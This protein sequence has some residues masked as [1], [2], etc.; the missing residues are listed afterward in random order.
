MLKKEMQNLNK[1]SF[2]KS[3]LMLQVGEDIEGKFY[4]RPIRWGGRYSKGKLLEG[5]CL[6]RFDTREDAEDALINISGYSKELTA[7]LSS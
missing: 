2:A 1:Y 5:E 3:N 4:I 7:Q 6:A